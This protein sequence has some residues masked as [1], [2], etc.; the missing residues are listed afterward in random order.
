MGRLA[1]TT[2]ALLFALAVGKPATAQVTIDG[3]AVQVTT[4]VT[5]QLDPSIDGDLV[6]YSDLSSG[7]ADVYYTDLSTGVESQVTTAPGFQQLQDV[8]GGV[9]V[10]SELSPATGASVIQTHDVSTG[11]TAPVVSATA[12]D[13]NPT[14]SG[15]VVAFQGLGASFDIYAYDLSVGATMAITATAAH[16]TEP[17][18]DGSRIVYQRL[19][20][21]RWD[22]LLFD[23]ST[24]SE[25]LLAAGLATPPTPDLS[26]DTVVWVG[27]VAGDS[28]IMVLDLAT[29]SAQ[30]L[31]APGDQNRPR[32]SGAMLAYDDLGG[33]DLDVVVRHLPSGAERRIGGAVGS[34]EFLNDLT[35]GRVAYTSDVSG[36]F[37]IW[38]YEFTL[39]EP[40]PPGDLCEGGATPDESYVFDEDA[41][42][43]IA[44]SGS[45]Q[46]VVRAE[47]D[48]EDTIVSLDGA[49]LLGEEDFASGAAC[50]SLAVSVAGGEIVSVALDDDHDDDGETGDED[51]HAGCTHENQRGQ[52]HTEH[53]N[54][55]GYGH[56]KDRG[57]SCSVS[58]ELYLD[59]PE[60]EPL[61]SCATGTGGAGLWLLLLVLGG[62]A[63]SR[64]QER[65]PI[66][67]RHSDR[68]FR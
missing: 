15:G 57:E 8:G 63:L 9:I 49:T 11:L 20:G 46:L 56:Y 7:D 14:I 59:A 61:A 50:W 24:N 52:G 44:G 65:A 16:E 29:G 66:R 62:L 68:R 26:G 3:A 51:D 10:Y 40:P 33:T 36:N 53:G 23:L 19:S 54:G 60:S 64:R 25:Q 27:G 38:V 4:R 17:R 37:D 67:V 47:G 35:E 31:A 18:V 42:A 48:C 2:A 1:T 58:V 13:S 32:V 21:T 22:V 55:N 41:S 12:N 34:V 28:D 45:G 6:V 5:S 30:T 39:S 43:T